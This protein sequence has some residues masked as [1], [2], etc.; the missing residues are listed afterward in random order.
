MPDDISAMPPLVCPAA[1]ID[2]LCA[3]SITDAK[4]AD[5]AEIAVVRAGSGWQKLSE[6][7]PLAEVVSIRAGQDAPWHKIRRGGWFGQVT[8]NHAGVVTG[9]AGDK[10]NPEASVTVLAVDKAGTVVA[11]AAT[12]TD[13][14]TMGRFEIRLPASVRH[15]PR[16]DRLTLVIEGSDFVLRQGRL[17]IG[18]GLGESAP[19]RLSGLSKSDPVIAIKIS[20]PNLKEAPLWGDYHFANSLAASFARIGI[21]ARVDTQDNWYSAGNQS[22]VD[23]AIRGR[24]R[25]DVDGGKIN[26]MWLISHPDRVPDEEFADYDHVTVASEI[27]ARTLRQTGLADAIVMHQATDARLFGFVPQDAPRLPSC[28]FVGNSR[29]EYRTMVKWCVQ[30]DIPLELYGGGWDGILPPGAVRAPS[31]ANKD[32]PNCYG[33]HL[34]LLNDHW[35]SMR[36]N[37]F[38]SNRLFDGSAT[39]TPILTD[40]VAGLEK[41]FGDTISQAEDAGTFAAKIRDCLENPDAWLRRAARAREIVL[42]AHTFDHRAAEIARLIGLSDLKNPTVAQS[43]LKASG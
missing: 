21:H 23:L 5:G 19:V 16:V 20:T 11:H 24:H 2:G 15:A 9:A 33:S 39:G 6:T 18:A 1:F 43:A 35:D 31:V 25:L 3:P 13:P 29:R 27:Y 10:M 17:T 40:A 38:L 41:V 8:G 34:L 32:L 26:L 36:G 22:D 14:Q 37:G 42:G 7:D 4:A 12:Q 30:K 28:L